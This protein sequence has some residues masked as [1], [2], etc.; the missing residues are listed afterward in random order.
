M[1]NTLLVNE[2]KL[3]ALCLILVILGLSACPKAERSTGMALDNA[4]ELIDEGSDKMFVEPKQSKTDA[5]EEKE[6]QHRY[7]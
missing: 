4:N 3:K 6:M 5:E 7:Y 1:P 2:M